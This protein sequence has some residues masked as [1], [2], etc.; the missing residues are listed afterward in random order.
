M[1]RNLYLNTV[2]LE[3]ALSVFRSRTGGGLRPGTE[4]V[5]VVASLGRTTAEAVFARISSPYN[6]ASAMDG[7]AVRSEA[8]VGADERSPVVL[9]RDRDYR[10]VDTGDV[11]VDPYDSVIM[12]EDVEEIDERHV[13]IT[14]ASHPWQHVRMIGEDLVAGEMVVTSR[15]RI[16]PEDVAAMI[17]GGV[18]E[19]KVI[20]P[21][22]VGVIPTGTEIVEPGTEM[23]PGAILDSNSFMLAALVEEAGGRP[24]RMP[25]VPDDRDRL[26][27][28]LLK[29]VEE[30]D[31]TIINAGSSAGTEDHT[32]G[33]IR[34]LGE[35]WI[36]GIDIKPG[37]P[38]ILGAIGGKPV[39]GIPGYPV[40]AY[41]TFRH[42]VTPILRESAGEARPDLGAASEVRAEAEDRMIRATLTRRVVSSLRHRE[43]VRVQIGPVNGRF[44]ATPLERGAGAI[45]SLV[46]ANGILTVPKES[47][48][49]ESGTEVEIAATRPLEDIA[50][51]IVSIGSHDPLMDWIADL[52]ERNGSGRHLLSSHVGSLGGMLAVRRGEAQLAPIHLL[53]SASGTYNE[54]WVRRH[55]PDDAMVLV[56]GI[57]RWQGFYT[58]E[59]M[60]LE[61]GFL[62]VARDRLRFIN[63]Q[64]GSGTR[65]L[66][67]HLLKQA[68]I[69]PSSLSGYETELPTH[70]AVALA[71]QAG[72]ADIGVGVESVAR[73]MGLCW[74]PI[75]LEDY[76]FL[77]PERA[78]KDPGIAAFLEVLGSDA[79]RAIL[80]REGGYEQDPPE[81]VRIG[82]GTEPIP[83]GPSRTGGA[84]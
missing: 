44:V 66:T 82:N 72:N 33:L 83:S 39:I 9:E 77:I 78:L 76:D 37:R 57:R 71:V 53:D 24:V 3:E 60:P 1:Q 73:H 26:R 28:A 17:A 30:N 13:R 5:P 40:S 43:F 36:H 23:T 41:M 51:G 34:E 21:P 35:V 79:L 59:P 54:T 42:F 2:T 56:K 22:L 68:G 8:T 38:A 46:K 6:N 64:K 15:R 7:I 50:R 14:A 48:G 55:F 84:P 63:R 11:I 47:E 18:S 16:G 12:I 4:T 20:R 81:M 45:M 27:A 10:I 75:G 67:D 29:S 70:T 58:R 80:V 19:A 31:L 52:L 25:I 65:L 62:A 74:S 69:A 32:V 49:I 61:G